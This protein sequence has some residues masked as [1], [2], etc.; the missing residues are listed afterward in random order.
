MELLWTRRI[1]GVCALASLLG[2][3]AGAQEDKLAAAADLKKLS[4]EELMEI[5]VTSVSRRSERLAGAAAAIAVV[6]QEDIRRSGATSLP[7]ALRLVNSL[8]VARQTQGT[9]AVSARGFNLTTAN[10]MLVLIDGRSVYTPLFSGVFWDV[11]DTLLED[12]ERIEV[13]R[14]PG[15]TL[16]GANAVNGIINVITKRAADTQ[17]GLLA[18]GAGDEE[19]GFGGVRYGGVIG[20]SG[21]SGHYRVYGKYFDRDSMVLVDGSDAGDPMRMGQGGFRADWG[22]AGRDA[23]TVQGD[24]YTG[25]LGETTRDDTDLDGGNLLGRW[26]RT[27]S[28]ESDLELQVYWDRTHRRIPNLFEEHLDTLDLDFQH[29]LPLADRHDLVWGFGY[30][31]HH[32]RVGNSPAVAFLP[33]RR[34]FDLFSIF[35]QDEISLLEDRLNVTVGTKLE[36]NNS[37]GL[38]VQPSVRAAWMA[39]ERRTLWAAVSRAVRTPTR[40]DEDVVFFLPD[41]SPLLVG[42]RDFESEEVTAWEL[43]YRIQPHPELLLD[44]AAFYNVYDQ[45]RSLEPPADRPFPITLAN[46]LE[47][48]TWGIELRSNMQPVSGWRLQVGYAWL[49]KEFRRDQGGRDPGEGMAE[50]NDPEHRATLRSSLDLPAGLELD[51]WLRYVSELPSPFVDGYTELDLHL[52]WQ[53]TDALGLAL[54]GR[55]LLHGSHAEF[56][57]AGPLREEVERSVYG[58]VVWRF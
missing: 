13:I 17:G 47:A 37:T 36:H 26:S 57:P 30:R 43:G 24:A 52:G 19:R 49:D 44:V 1:A 16:W 15:A 9:W 8:H 45:L 35:A 42:S 14:G 58:K 56:G 21:T 46:R 2:S 41:G 54:V 3:P 18:A 32:D 27:F 55:N 40:I 51:A 25:R 38:E 28:E 11:Q 53:A 20:A 5:D 23:F 12:V 31:Y 10:K 4:I 6:T 34:D 7:Q 29:R 50:G 33:A 39:S 48:E 22:G